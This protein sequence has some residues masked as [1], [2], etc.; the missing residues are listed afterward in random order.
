MDSISGPRETPSERSVYVL[1]FG[2]PIANSSEYYCIL[3][4]QK[5]IKLRIQHSA[6]AY[7]AATNSYESARNNFDRFA[8][9]RQRASMSPSGTRFDPVPISEVDQQILSQMSMEVIA[10]QANRD[11]AENR[12]LALMHEFDLSQAHLDQVKR[13]IGEYSIKEAASFYDKIELVQREIRE[14]DKLIQKIIEEVER[15]K[16]RYKGAMLRLEEVSN[17]VRLI[18]SGEESEEVRSLEST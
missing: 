1:L 9:S 7:K 18:Q 16:E 5:G 11:A 2:D 6:E 4:E 14:E 15:T 12:Y 10:S 13:K 17:G 3:S 8:D